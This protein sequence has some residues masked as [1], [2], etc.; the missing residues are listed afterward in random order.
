MKQTLRNIET[1]DVTVTSARHALPAAERAPN[2][3]ARSANAMLR[4]LEPLH[5][6]SEGGRR[7]TQCYTG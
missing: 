1:P 5:S 6:W 2:A 4:R 3:T 7:E